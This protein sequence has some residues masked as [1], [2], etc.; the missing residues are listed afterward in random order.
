MR[1]KKYKLE[2][3]SSIVSQFTA[4]TAFVEDGT[5][6]ERGR[7]LAA[8]FFP[9]RE[10]VLAS[11]REVLWIAW[12]IQKAEK[13]FW[14]AQK[15]CWGGGWGPQHEWTDKRHSYIAGLRWHEPPVLTTLRP[16][17][18][19]GF[20][21]TWQNLPVELGKK[22]TCSLGGLSKKIVP[23]VFAW[24]PDSECTPLQKSPFGN[25]IGY[26]ICRCC[27]QDQ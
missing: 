9:P 17:F 16:L 1:L 24:N 25:R 18:H 22:S 8:R 26:C 11:I 5:S 15:S 23:I 3:L 4:L 2:C 13:I 21:L 14:G 27:D 10:N 7:H 6:R 20:F 19:L 12:N